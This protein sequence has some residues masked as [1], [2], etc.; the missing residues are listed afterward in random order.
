MN[1]NDLLKLLKDAKEVEEHAVP[2]YVKHLSS[3]VFWT[4]ISREKAEEARK[5]LNKLASDSMGHK[6]VVLQLISKINQAAED[7]I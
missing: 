7:D 4:G 6:N 2:I 5:I 1:R 3:A